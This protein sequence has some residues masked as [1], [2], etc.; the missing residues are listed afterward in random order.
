MYE[1]SAKVAETQELGIVPEC[2]QLSARTPIFGKECFRRGRCLSFPEDSACGRRL[3]RMS[4]RSKWFDLLTKLD[5]LE[6]H[7]AL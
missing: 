2:M 4:S 7:L 3:T 6:H 1:Q 5:E